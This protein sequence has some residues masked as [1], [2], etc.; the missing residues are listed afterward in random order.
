MTILESGNLSPSIR[1]MKACK[2]A[3]ETFTHK[4]E[5]DVCDLPPAPK[6]FAYSLDTAIALKIAGPVDPHT[7]E[8]MG[9]GNPDDSIGLFWL[10]K[11]NEGICAHLM[12]ETESLRMTSGTYAFFHDTK[13]HALI[14]RK[15]WTGI[16]VQLCRIK[17]CI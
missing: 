17:S 6:G 15:T 12:V 9:L 2:G 13:L 16:A 11:E 5:L 3:D 1:V 14:A 10:L 8:Y 7:D 4:V